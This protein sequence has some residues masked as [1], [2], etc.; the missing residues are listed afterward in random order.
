MTDSRAVLTA[1][2]FFTVPFMFE[3]I[4]HKTE[5]ITYIKCVTA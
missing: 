1:V 4:I 2:E 5:I 3:L